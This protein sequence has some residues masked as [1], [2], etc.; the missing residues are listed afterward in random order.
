M[1][2]E[3]NSH[4]H[5]DKHV[6]NKQASKQASKAVSI[7]HGYSRHINVYDVHCINR[8]NMP[9]I[10]YLMYLVHETAIAFVVDYIY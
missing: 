7:K 8:E 9:N 4:T 3:E 10:V 6:S 1:A 2:N 5:T